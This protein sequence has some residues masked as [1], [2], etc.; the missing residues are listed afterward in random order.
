MKTVMSSFRFF[1]SW[2]GTTRRGMPVPN[3]ILLVLVICLL[4]LIGCLIESQEPVGETPAIINTQEW[5]GTWVSHESDAG[6]RVLQ[7]FN[8]PQGIFLMKHKK[9]NAKKKEENFE[10]SWLYLRQSGDMLFASWREVGTS[11]F[12]WGGRI[13]NRAMEDRGRVMLLWLPKEGVISL[14]I[15]KGDLPVSW[16]GEKGKKYQILGP[17][18]PHHYQVLRDHEQEIFF[19]GNKPIV[20]VR[21]AKQ[22]P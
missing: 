11:T 12:F 9:W 8:P 10:T 3:K 7:I 16:V 4:T 20:L 14:L 6:T 17:L 21:L 19:K 15:K 22:S 2:P 1:L 18:L 5:E 13:E